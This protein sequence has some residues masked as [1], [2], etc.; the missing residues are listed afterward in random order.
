MRLKKTPTTRPLW[1]SRGKVNEGV[2]QCKFTVIPTER[3]EVLFPKSTLRQAN[4]CSIVFL[5]LFRPVFS[6][7]S[8][9]RNTTRHYLNVPALP[10]PGVRSIDEAKFFF[11]WTHLD[12]GPNRKRPRARRE[13]VPGRM[14]LGKNSMQD[15]RMVLLLHVAPSNRRWETSKSYNF[16]GSMSIFTWTSSA[17]WCFCCL[18]FFWLTGR[19]ERGSRWGKESRILEDVWGIRKRDPGLACS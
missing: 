8:C 6:S 11:H 19:A 1:A 4:K 13:A 9:S 3:C 16:K 12:Q 7:N 10:D 5:C 14:H 15:S 17:A 2:T 18:D